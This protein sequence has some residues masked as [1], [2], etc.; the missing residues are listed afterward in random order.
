M[1][2]FEPLEPRALLA[3]VSGFVFVDVNANAVRDPDLNLTD[4]VSPPDK[5]LPSVFD[6]PKDAPGV[7]LFDPG[8]NG[9]IGGGD[10]VKVRST[11]LASDGSYA[12][13][14][15]PAGSYIVRLARV[16]D[17]YRVVV[18]D[19]VGESEDD[20]V[21]APQRNIDS[22][23]DAQGRSPVFQLAA[24]G[25][26]EQSIGLLRTGAK[27]RISAVFRGLHGDFNPINFGTLTVGR[28]PKVTVKWINTGNRP[29]TIKNTVNGAE[30]LGDDPTGPFTGQRWVFLTNLAGKT[31]NPGDSVDVS[32]RYLTEVPGQFGNK[33]AFVPTGRNAAAIVGPIN[34]TTTDVVG[35]GATFRQSLRQPA[36]GAATYRF[37]TMYASWKPLLDRGTIDRFDIEVVGPNN[38]RQRAR[39]VTRIDAD[40]DAPT[41][42][43]E[44]FNADN[45]EVVYQIN[46]PGGAWDPNDAGQ[47]QFRVLDKA[48]ADEEGNGI[49]P[50]LLQTLR[51]RFG[52]AARRGDVER[53]ATVTSAVSTL[54]ELPVGPSSGAPSLFSQSPVVLDGEDEAIFER[55]A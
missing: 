24:D 11:R 23:A 44:K 7:T 5:G 47:Y 37:K 18:K 55:I 8:P 6:D 51:V 22:D 42:D 43:P 32:M 12:F 30:R 19:I 26:A 39:L 21:P 15:L 10:D 3:S 48:V 16:P 40:D 2:H 9:R 17:G 25:Q 35:V 46:A 33:G 38:F 20:D 53:V 52:Q 50:R 27:A 13:G 31:L 29:I 1:S 34:L 45:R 4:A 14:N 28:Q 49:A 36:L 41:F 54:T